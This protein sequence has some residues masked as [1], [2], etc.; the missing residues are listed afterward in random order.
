MDP[1]K[2]I[3][4]VATMVYQDYF[5]LERWYR[6]YDKQVG[7]ENLYVF[8]HGNDPRHRE[9][10]KHANVI[11]LPRDDTMFKFDRRRWRALGNCATG[12]LEFYNWIIVTDVDEIVI[13]DPQSASTIQ[14]Y[15][16]SN[17][18]NSKKSPKNLAPFCLELIHLP[19]E[20]P[21][22]ILDHETILSRRRIFRPNWNYS[23]PCL[24]SGPV[25][26][27]PGG[28]RN[29]LGRRHMPPDLYTL[30]LKYFDYATME[31]I[32]SEKKQMVLNAGKLGSKYDET[33]GWYKTLDHYRN[34]VS[35]TSLAGEDIRLPEYRAAMMRQI[36]RY[37]NQFIW[38]PV[39]C[40]KLYRIPARFS[41]VF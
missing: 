1:T 40:N 38:G 9:I 19:D 12:L 27:G 28:H 36:E 30:H 2:S 17:Y 35:S 33:H 16:L 22:P 34:I 15:L 20:E 5:F 23:K 21:L 11:N 7:A 10:A 41:D 32:A 3:L 14:D 39:Q 24:V 18:A 4:A 13:V 26:F 29:T 8:S 31:G 37:Q 25:V 6:Y